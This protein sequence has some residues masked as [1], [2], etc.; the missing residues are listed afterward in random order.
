MEYLHVPI[1]AWFL[2]ITL[3]I[4]RR[5]SDTFRHLQMAS[6]R[7]GLLKKHIS[8]EQ[9]DLFKK[10]LSILQKDSSCVREGKNFLEN[11]SESSHDL[12]ICKAE[13]KI[14]SI[15]KIDLPAVGNCI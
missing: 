8:E 15:S 11:H 14:H 7:S 3:W 9:E 2:V 6:S 5:I 4:L 13:K 12:T 1:K 10:R